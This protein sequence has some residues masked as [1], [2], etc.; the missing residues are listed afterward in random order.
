M[1]WSRLSGVSMMTFEAHS[2]SGGMGWDG[3][4]QGVV[5]LSFPSRDTLVYT[6]SGTW[7]PTSYDKEITF[8]NTFRWTLA[9]DKKAITLEHLRFGVNHPV[10]LFE[11]RPLNPTTWHT[12]TPHICNQDVYNATI[13]LTPTALQVHWTIKGPNKNESVRYGYWE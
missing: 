3:I 11:L 8:R 1:L 12:P 4:G 7:T 5:K 2:A 6:E 9:P 13:H 10:F